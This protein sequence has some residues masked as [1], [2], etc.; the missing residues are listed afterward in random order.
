[1]AENNDFC[2]KQPSH[3]DDDGRGLF[4]S[5][6]QSHQIS[7][8]AMRPSRVLR[9]WS[10]LC[11]LLTAAGCAGPLAL[12]HS[13]QKYNQ[14]I[15]TT[16]SEQLLLNLVRLRY[17]DVPSFMQL[18]SLSTQFAFGEGAFVSGGIKETKLSSFLNFGADVDV[19]ERPTATYDPLQ[20]QEFVKRMISPLGEDTIILLVRSGW[21]VD[22]VLRMAVQDL[23]GMENARRASGA[24]PR[25]ISQD[26]YFE[27]QQI[28]ELLHDLQVDGKLR[29][30]YEP[31]EKLLSG[32]I[33]PDT[34]DS[35]AIVAAAREGWKIQPKQERVSIAAE[36]IALSST[37]AETY[38]EEKLFQNF[39]EDVRRLGQQAPIRVRWR[40]PDAA[41][42][43]DSGN[44]AETDGDEAKP[45]VTV[46]GEFGDLTL[47]ACR[48]LDEEL[49][50]C[51]LEY[52]DDYILTGPGDRL[53]LS[54]DLDLL[55]D[56]DEK[57]LKEHFKLENMEKVGRHELDLE[58]RSLMGTMYYL[59][60][61]IRVPFEHE[62]AGLVVTTL[63][64]RGVPFDWAQL[65]DDLLYVHCQK[66][67]PLCAAV[68][69]H[70]RG[71]WFYIDDRDHDSKATF[72]LL[73]Q[74]FELQA[75]GGATGT[76]PVLT[77]P[78]G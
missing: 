5:Y 21:N 12:R 45:F 37:I 64:E 17:R 73:M 13:R 55:S 54:W 2:L 47:L 43:P 15:Q 16:A 40:E 51:I 38:R 26:E 57:R 78:V 74:L 60:H 66:K 39:V 10:W 27:F 70:Y 75:G 34:V 59:S 1:M 62:A 30:G 44:A 25:D 69:V 67:K 14:V 3:I 23:N 42:D 7:E 58:P 46:P 19:A 22:R 72:T 41:P 36:K 6:A 77:L 32:A 33:P 9:T 71:Y 4:S 50:D 11:L 29:I 8:S 35:D 49:I 53:V 28:V 68:A 18:S 63:D 20:G 61:A 48:E 76:K 56:T 24:T 65:T 31:S 52:P